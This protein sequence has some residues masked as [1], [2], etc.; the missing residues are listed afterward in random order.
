MKNT[1]PESVTG[2]GVPVGK[3]KIASQN[4]V[5]SIGGSPSSVA[6]GGIGQRSSACI[7]NGK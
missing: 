6:K 2:N 4:R 7:V 1:A 3:P 5:M